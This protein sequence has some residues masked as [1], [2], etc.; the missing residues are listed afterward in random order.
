MWGQTRMRDGSYPDWYQP[1]HTRH[2]YNFAHLTVKTKTNT[3]LICELMFA[4]YTASCAHSLPKLQDI[5]NALSASCNMFGLKISTKEE[6]HTC[7]KWSTTPHPNQWQVTGNSRPGLLLRIMIVKMTT[8]D[9]EVSS[10]IGKVATSWE[11]EVT[12]MG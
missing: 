5:C 9:T 6:G 3:V 1:I 7:Y 4:N 2:L 10:Q 11:T 8:L 12:C